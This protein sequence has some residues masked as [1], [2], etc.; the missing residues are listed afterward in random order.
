M[1]TLFTTLLLQATEQPLRQALLPVQAGARKGHTTSTH[2]LNLW[3][4]LLQHDSP[5]YVCLLDV[6]KAFPSTPHAAIL[7]ALYCIGAP[8]HLL[9]LVEQIYRRP[10]NKCDGFTYRVRRGIKEG[11]PLSA[12]VFTLVYQSFHGDLQREFG[13]VDYVDDRAFIARSKLEL[14]AVHHQVQETSKIL[15]FKINHTKTEITH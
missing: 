13:N 6:T 15:G 4:T 7:Q 8:A 14:R 1:Y 10:M 2:A 5:Q 12:T 11:C 9:N 3:T